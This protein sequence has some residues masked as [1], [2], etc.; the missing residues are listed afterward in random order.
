MRVIIIS[1]I[2]LLT[3]CHYSPSNQ[4]SGKLEGC[5]S[6]LIDR[7][8][9]ET[10]IDLYEID[11]VFIN[12]LDTIVESEKR[13]VNYDECLTGFQLITYINSN[14]FEFLNIE[15]IPNIYT[16]D[17]SQCKGIFI[18]KNFHFILLHTD[19]PFLRRKYSSFKQ[20]HI[21]IEEQPLT[22]YDDRWS[23]WTFQLDGN[24]YILKNHFQC[25]TK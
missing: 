22:G 20:K 18:Y 24:K 16:F 23:A 2:I 11:S 9:F 7:Q 4:K 8:Y 12:Y 15:T 10:I 6:V 25:E 3:G 21:E 17:Y 19:I 5:D 14:G 13:C 1:L